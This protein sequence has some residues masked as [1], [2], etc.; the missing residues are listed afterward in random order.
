MR[1]ADFVNRALATRSEP[2]VGK[3]GRK[4]T[5]YL[6]ETACRWPV[7]RDRA[8][9]APSVI[10][11]ADRRPVPLQRVLATRLRAPC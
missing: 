9:Q 11:A 5:H 6:C 3:T 10:H 2:S 1:N 8:Q 4:R 7:A